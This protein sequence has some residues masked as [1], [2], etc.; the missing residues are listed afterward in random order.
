MTWHPPTRDTGEFE[1]DRTNEEVQIRVEYFQIDGA[2]ALSL[3]LTPA[4]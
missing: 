3:D 2:A 4:E 1:Q